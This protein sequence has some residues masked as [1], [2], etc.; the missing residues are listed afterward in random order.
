[1]ELQL[2]SD[3]DDKLESVSSDLRKT[4]SVI[5]QIS[6]KKKSEHLFSNIKDSTGACSYP[7]RTANNF[8]NFFA[9]IEPSLASKVPST[10]FSH[11]DFL[12]GHFADCFFLDP[13]SPAEI[14]SIVH[15]LKIANVRVLMVFLCLPSKKQLIYLLLLYLI[16]ATYY[17]SMVSFLINSKLQR[18][19][20]FLKVMTLLCSQ[21]IALFLFFP[22]FLRSSR[23]YFTSGYQD[24]S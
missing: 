22:I 6:S 8:N 4:W 19:S 18:F 9:N 24:F 17:L 13:T 5:K 20:Q 2:S 21:T 23:N 10:Q 7:S 14:A 15:S 3:S 12:V 1:M 16:F 11:K